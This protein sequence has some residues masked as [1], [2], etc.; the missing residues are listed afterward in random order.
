[1]EILNF[2]DILLSWYLVLFSLS[3][4][5]DDDMSFLCLIF[6][7]ERLMCNCC[8][9]ACAEMFFLCSY[10]FLGTAV[11]LYCPGVNFWF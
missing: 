4:M 3:P 5:M 6:L 7:F 1:M 9:N 2:G 10:Q 11:G 8:M